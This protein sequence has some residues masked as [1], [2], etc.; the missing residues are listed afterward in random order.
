VPPR[1]RKKTPPKNTASDP[2]TF[3]AE[4]VVAGRIVAG[5]WVR[6]SCARHL[7]DLQDGPKRGL[8]WDLDAA[9]RAI[10]FFPDVLCLNGGQFEGRP[11]ELH[12]SQKFRVGS[13]FGWRKTD[14]R[15][16]FRR[17]Y[18]EEGKGNGKSPMLAGIGLYCLLADDEARAEVYAAASK[19]DQ[20]MVLFRDAVAMVDQSPALLRR[21]TK[22]GGNPVWNLADLKTGS[23]FRPISSDDGQSGP[24]PHCALCDEVHE[25]RNRDTIDMLE[26]GFKWRLQPL[27]CMATNSG[28]DRTSICWEE[29]CHAIN[30]ARGFDDNGLPVE[31]DS[32]FSYV[33]ALDEGDDP[34]SDPS[35]W[36]KAN[37]LLGVTVMEETLAAA[38]K[39]ALQMPGKANS[40]KRLNFCI[41]TDA[42]TA[43]I[44]KELWD[45]VQGDFD[46]LDHV[47]RRVYGGLD[48]SAVKDLTA[49]AHIVETGTVERPD[50]AGNVKL[51]PTF[52]AWVD[53]WTPAATLNERALADK[54]PYEIWVDEG[55]LHAPPGRL[56]RLDF[57]AQHMLEESQDFEFAA[58]AYDRYAIRNLEGELDEIGA[59]LPIIEHPQGFRRVSVLRDADGEVI[60]DEDNKQVENP[61]WM[62]SSINGLEALILDGR[63]RIRPNP[64][65]TWNAASACFDTDPQG[66]RKFAKQK[67]TGRIDGMVALAMAV[68]AALADVKGATS[69]ST[70]EK[71]GLLIL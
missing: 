28:T 27:L 47:G 30:V 58:I 36:P 11:F 25:H 17:F 2:V 48:L 62:P 29:H 53:F 67:A 12:L 52:D 51:L 35:C 49:E 64:V 14:G 71:R 65:L 31:D 37:P 43:W 45:S 61:L 40:I 57:V 69:P 38:A 9:L 16:R 60:R 5:P 44:T 33:C 59:T 21:I 3:Y 26:R 56:V 32:T 15:R 70:Y 7:R 54:V 55:H 10:N 68:G 41:W 34:L 1:S 42:E 18:D 13:L 19:K 4:E 23:F 63:I 24:R 22:S 66:N 8:R 6:A 20:A 39:Q 46:P 50:E